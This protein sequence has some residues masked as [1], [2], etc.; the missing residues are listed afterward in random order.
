MRFNFLGIEITIR[1]DYIVIGIIMLIMIL[2]LWGWYL[3]TIQAEVF[4]TD[5][6]NT[7]KMTQVNEKSGEKYDD[8]EKTVAGKEAME[9]SKEPWFIN[10]NTADKETLMKL[11]GIGEVKAAAIIEYREKN[12]LFKNTEEIKNVKG[13]GEATFS[14]IKDR[15][16]VGTE[17]RKPCNPELLK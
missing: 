11:Y 9:T 8:S 3:K 5:N 7:E 6:K 15:I 14:K 12:G 17:L 16:I 4:D 13:I 10:I 2:V 1:K